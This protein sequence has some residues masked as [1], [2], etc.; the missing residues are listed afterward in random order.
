MRNDKSN[1]KHKKE[2][3]LDENLSENQKLMKNYIIQDKAYLEMN[4]K[5]MCLSMHQPWASL[6]V[7]G[8]KKLVLLIFFTN[9]WWYIFRHEGRTWYTPHRGTLWIAATAKIPEP[10]TIKEIENFYEKYYEGLTVKFPKKYPTGVLLGNVLVQDCLGQ[11]EY[12]EEFPNGES[13]SPYVFIC[14][15]PNKLV[16]PIPVK[17]SHKICKNFLFTH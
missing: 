12:R 6:L 8:I 5:G 10:E 3:I 9:L 14:S 7:L 13:E 15:D 1:Y 2:G 16:V 17:G 4:D 11:D